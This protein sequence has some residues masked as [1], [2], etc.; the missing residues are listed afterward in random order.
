MAALR[1]VFTPRAEAQLARLHTYIAERSGAP[2]A[3]R[4]VGAIVAACRAM[5]AFPQRGTKRDEVR[6]G[7]RTVGFKRRVTIA[8]SLEGDAV[9]IHGVLYGGRDYSR[10]L[11]ARE[12]DKR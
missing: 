10:I 6:P 2:R 12:D 9:V 7:L 4:Y 3:E 1:V 8:F 11:A 5:A